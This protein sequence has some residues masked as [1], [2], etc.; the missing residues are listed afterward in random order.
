MAFI[1]ALGVVLC[2]QDGMTMPSVGCYFNQESWGWG[3]FA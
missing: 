2:V 3:S 1:V